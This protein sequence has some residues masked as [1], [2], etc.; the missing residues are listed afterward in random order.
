MKPQTGSDGSDN[1]GAIAGAT[2]GLGVLSSAISGFGKYEQGQQQQKA[3]DYNAAVTTLNT[4]NKVEANTQ[5]FAERM[6]RQ[7]TAYA[8]AGVDIASGSPYLIMLAT[9][10]R[11]AQQSEQIEE[12]GTEEAAL[13]RYYG[14]IAAF[15]G[16]MSGISSFLNGVSADASAYTK[17]T[18]NPSSSGTGPSVGDLEE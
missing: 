16:T 4:A 9:A 14:K 6:G 17:G 10:A 18:F 2:F 11:G 3:Y 13:Q 1:S 5:T 15:G 8:G 12:A 7:A